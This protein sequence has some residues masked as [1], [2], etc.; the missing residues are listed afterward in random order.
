MTAARAGRATVRH[1]RRSP[2]TP[3]PARRPCSA[4]TWP[5]HCPRCPA[6]AMRPG[7]CHAGPSPPEAPSCRSQP[8]HTPGSALASGRHRAGPP[9][10]AGEPGPGSSRAREAWWPATYPDLRRRS[11]PGSQRADHPPETCT[12]SATSE[13][14]VAAGTRTNAST[15]CHDRPACPAGHF[16]ARVARKGF[17][18]R[19]HFRVTPRPPG[20]P[21]VQR[22]GNRIDRRNGMAALRPAPLDTG[23]DATSSAAAQATPRPGRYEID[24]SFGGPVPDPAPVR[25]RRRCAARSRSGPG[26]SR[27][28]SRSPTR[29]SA[30]RSTRRASAPATAARTPASARRASWQPAGTRSSRS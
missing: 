26:R 8:G 10:A 27:S 7:A 30:P 12:L 29:A 23:A 15:R 11:Q 3:G 24:T 4:R 21:S 2:G 28:P 22:T 18:R 19:V 9:A 13:P 25:A 6:T 1:A 17:T 14:P 16:R 20:S 5:G